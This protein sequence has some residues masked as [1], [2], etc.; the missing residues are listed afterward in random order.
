MKARRVKGIDA[1][2][3]LADGLEKVV[4]VRADELFALAAIAQDPAEVGAAHD[5][6]IAAKRLRYAL[7]ISAEPC[8]GPYAAKAIKRCRELQDLLGELHDCD[9]AL[10]RVRELQAQ[11]RSADALEARARAGDAQDL[12][13]VHASGTP[14]AQDWRGLE[15]LRIY[16]QARRGLL[17]ERFLDA[18]REIERDGFGARLDY[19]LRERPAFTSPSPDA[20]AGARESRA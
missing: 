2:G 15:A 7:E 19:A 9:V 13:P 10:P 3:P 16:Y 20:H 8:F 5:L 12:S 18:W 6:R 4:R 14:H 17:F 11:L 1:H